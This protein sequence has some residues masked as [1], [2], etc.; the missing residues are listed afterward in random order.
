MEGQRDL[1]D[2]KVNLTFEKITCADKGSYTCR[3]VDGGVETNTSTVLDIT[4]AFLSLSVSPSVC[5]SV[6]MSMCA[7][8]NK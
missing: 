3:A 1:E 5:L 4:R 7:R 8:V 2:L 6:C